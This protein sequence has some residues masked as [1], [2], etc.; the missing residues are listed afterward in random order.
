MREGCLAPDGNVPYPDMVAPERSGRIGIPSPP[1][2]AVRPSNPSWSVCLRPMARRNCKSLGQY[3]GH[4]GERSRIKQVTYPPSLP[5]GF[6]HAARSLSQKGVLAV[7]TTPSSPPIFADSQ[8]TVRSRPN[9]ILPNPPTQHT[10]NTTVKS[11][12]P[13]RYSLGLS[14]FPRYHWNSKRTKPSIHSV[15]LP[16]FLEETLRNPWRYPCRYTAGRRSSYSNSY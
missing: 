10:H 4:Q 1:S 7:P 12:K 15:S 11:Q 9:N 16:P 5:Y 8:V 14:L 13:S 6:H 2:H 3:R